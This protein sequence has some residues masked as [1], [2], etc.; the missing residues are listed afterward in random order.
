MTGLKMPFDTGEFYDPY[1]RMICFSLI[2]WAFFGFTLQKRYC[3]SE[4]DNDRST[5]FDRSLSFF[6]RQFLGSS[7]FPNPHTAGFER[8]G[9]QHGKGRLFDG[10]SGWGALNTHCCMLVCFLSTAF[11]TRRNSVKTPGNCTTFRPCSVP[12]TQPC[13]TSPAPSG[14]QNEDSPAPC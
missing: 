6:W 8:I 12:R 7:L 11:F 14:P 10:I 13:G 3:K 2:I 4:N 9:P 1:C 5:S